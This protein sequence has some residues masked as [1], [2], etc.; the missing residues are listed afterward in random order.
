MVLRIVLAAFIAFGAAMIVSGMLG[1][2][3]CRRLRRRGVHVEARI[4]SLRRVENRDSNAA[5]TY[6]CAIEYAAPDGDMRTAVIEDVGLRFFDEH[7]AG[8]TVDA[9]CDP[10]DPGTALTG[11]AAQR[12]QLAS[13]A[14][15]VIGVGIL[16]ATPL[17]ALVF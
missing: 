17:L 5:F 3:R 14:Q 4:T 1:L 9:V 16:A 7:H 13:A 8:D 12:R 10:S 11:Y 6:E 15:T 2:A